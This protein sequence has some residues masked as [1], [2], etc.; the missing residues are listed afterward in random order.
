VLSQAANVG[1]GGGQ[2]DIYNAAGAKAF[3]VTDPAR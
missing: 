3:K 2:F 1:L